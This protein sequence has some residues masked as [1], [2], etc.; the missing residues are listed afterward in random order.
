MTPITYLGIT[1]CCIIPQPYP[2]LG[3]TGGNFRTF[4]VCPNCES[5]TCSATWDADNAEEKIP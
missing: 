2:A 1:K 3:K 5:R 4:A